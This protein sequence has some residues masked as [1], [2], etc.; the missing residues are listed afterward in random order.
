MKLYKAFPEIDNFLSNNYFTDIEL[1]NVKNNLHKI[2]KDKDI[3]LQAKNYLELKLLSFKKTYVN[4]NEDEKAVVSRNNKIKRKKRKVKQAPARKE[5][6]EKN[7]DINQ[8]PI[9]TI[10]DF[11]NKVPTGITVKKLA[12]LL[13]VR[14]IVMIR[15]YKHCGIDVKPETTITDTLKTKIRKKVISIIGINRLKQNRGLFSNVKNNLKNKRKKKKKH[16][17]WKNK[18]H[19]IFD[20]VKFH[21]PDPYSSLNNINGPIKIIYTSM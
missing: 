19:S 4:Q 6:D 13:G 5:I 18:K 17:N 8:P 9:S 2:Y 10:Q 3:A 21:N 7:K 12:K 16:H 1:N 11:D 15:H 14:V 20:C